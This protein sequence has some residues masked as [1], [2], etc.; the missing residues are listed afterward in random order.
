[1][2]EKEEWGGVKGQ[3]QGC[4][5]GGSWHILVAGGFV[6]RVAESRVGRQVLGVG[7]MGGGHELAVGHRALLPRVLGP[8]R[9]GAGLAH[10]ALFLKHHVTERHAIHVTLTWCS[11]RPSRA[12]T[13]SPRHSTPRHHFTSVTSHRRGARLAHHA[14]FPKHHRHSTSRHVSHVTTHHVTSCLK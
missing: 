10:H 7:V 6:A 4:G 3:R 13:E 2:E 5:K 1:M 11:S 9:R 14:L 12:V 8:A